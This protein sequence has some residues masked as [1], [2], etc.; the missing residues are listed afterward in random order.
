MCWA[1]LCCIVLCAVCWVPCAL[2]SVRHTGQRRNKT[3][4]SQRIIWTFERK[5]VYIYT[6]INIRAR[7]VERLFFVLLLLLSSSNG[8]SF[9]CWYFFP[10]SSVFFF[11][12]VLLLRLRF[13]YVPILIFS[14]ILL[15]SLLSLTLCSCWKLPPEI[16]V[17]VDRSSSRAST[18]FAPTHKHTL[19]VGARDFAE[20]LVTNAKHSF[21][22]YLSI[23][24]QYE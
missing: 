8:I 1:E 17:G 5:S 16:G 20:S 24:I 3:A 15:M 2:C 7:W 22:F 10:S 21:W 19:T 13:I 18:S 23:D 12:F 4:S 6:S 14:F 11:R 9:C